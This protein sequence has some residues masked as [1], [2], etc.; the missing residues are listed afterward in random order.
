MTIFNQFY[1]SL[2][3]FHRVSSRTLFSRS[4]S[5]FILSI[6]DS[7]PQETNKSESNSEFRKTKMEGD[8][9]PLIRL[10][11]AL[12]HRRK[13][14]WKLFIF[15]RHYVVECLSTYGDWE[16]INFSLY[17][18]IFIGIGTNNNNNHI[19][20]VG[21]R[22]TCLSLQLMTFYIDRREIG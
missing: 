7:E 22:R 3:S 17:C 5:S 15:G 12:G 8:C 16:K 4:A 20:T 21:L 11:I 6:Y 9:W 18:F 19:I 10:F 2:S 13:T 14:I 1:S